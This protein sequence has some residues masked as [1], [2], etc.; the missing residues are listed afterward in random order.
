MWWQIFDGKGEKVRTGVACSEDGLYRPM[1]V[2]EPISS[3]AASRERTIRP[4][5]GKASLIHSASSHCTDRRRGLAVCPLQQ[6]CSLLLLK[7]DLGVLWVSSQRK[8]QLSNSPGTGGQNLKMTGKQDS[9]PSLGLW[10]MMLHPN[11][12][13]GVCMMGSRWFQFNLKQQV[14]AENL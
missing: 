7:A 5:E 6:L 13:K 3:Y 10:V 2:H 9:L 1:E 12:A 14:F 4:T 8:A 11:V